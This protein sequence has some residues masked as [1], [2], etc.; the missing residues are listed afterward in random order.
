[1]DIIS[2]IKRIQRDFDHLIETARDCLVGFLESNS[3]PP[4]L[5][6]QMISWSL[7]DTKAL[8]TQINDLH[9]VSHRDNLQIHS[10]SE[11][12][13]LVS[14]YYVPNSFTTLDIDSTL[15]RNLANPF[16]SDIY[17]L[18]EKE[19]PLGVFPHQNKL[20]QIVIGKRPTFQDM[21]HFINQHLSKRLVIIGLSLLSLSS[22]SLVS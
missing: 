10:K 21:F 22:L 5:P 11:R 3:S 6:H 16:I 14:Q 18:N 15:L 2:E 4:N 12:V 13:V 1:M 9:S 19:F 7:N 17:L 8:I 20:H